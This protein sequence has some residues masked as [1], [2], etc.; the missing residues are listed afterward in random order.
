MIVHLAIIL[1]FQLIG[2][3][4]ARGLDLSVPGPVVGM[5][6]LL[7]AFVLFPKAEAAIRPTAQGLLRH[8]SLL[9]VPAGVGV[10]GHLGALGSE[11]P[12]ILLALVVST[13]AAIAVG[14]LTFIAIARLTGAR[15]D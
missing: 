8:L 10:I 15:D 12:A 14:S 6:L 2:E 5:V 7:L 11:G 9:F 4:L 1:G 3:V 13:I